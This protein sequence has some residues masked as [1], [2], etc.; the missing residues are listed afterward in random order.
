MFFPSDFKE[1]SVSAETTR[2]INTYTLVRF[3]V[4]KSRTSE[5]ISFKKLSGNL[6]THKKKLLVKITR[7]G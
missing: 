3:V 7:A 1:K 4:Y 5:V 6:F 2:K